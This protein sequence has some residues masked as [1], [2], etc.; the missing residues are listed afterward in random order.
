[1]FLHRHRKNQSSNRLRRNETT[2]IH[3][4]RLRFRSAAVVCDDEGYRHCDQC[5]R[6]GSKVREGVIQCVG[7]GELSAWYPC[8]RRESY[9]W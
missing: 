3:S 5:E 2:R 9:G 6:S 4:G 8:R 1:M 7:E